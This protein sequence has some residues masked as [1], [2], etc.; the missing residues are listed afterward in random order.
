MKKLCLLF[1]LGC[2]LNSYAAQPTRIFALIV[3]ESHYKEPALNKLKYAESDAAAFA[4]FLKSPQAGAVPAENIIF[5][6]GERATR[7]AVLNAANELFNGRAQENDMIIFYFSGHGSSSLGGGYLMPYDA[8]DADPVSS[9]ISMGQLYDIINNSHAKM[10]A[11]YLDACHAGSYPHPAGSKGTAAEM[12]Q[13]ISRA[14]TKIIADSHPG[15]LNVLSSKGSEESQESETLHGGIF[16][17]YLIKGLQGEADKTPSDGHITADE[18]DD[19]LAKKVT[20]ESGFRQ[21]PVITRT[22]DNNF[23]LSIIDLNLTLADLINKAAV[24]STKQADNIVVTPSVKP[25]N[26]KLS[27]GYYFVDG[28]CFAKAT[29]INN[30]GFPLVM[31]GL[32]DENGYHEQSELLA[33]NDQLPTPKLVIK[34]F[35]NPDQAADQFYDCIFYFKAEINGVT[36][37]AIVRRTVESCFNQY[38]VL[39][40]RNVQFGDQKF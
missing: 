29:F 12:N 28:T 35:I 34:R 40:P 25:A 7:A 16:T 36:K 19:Y 13:E 39:T 14:F 21:H 37:Y 18:L 38:F 32:Q 30:L 4:G 17:Y 15:T 8:Q 26:E 3:G 24:Q 22:I 5:L 6:T 10:K 20:A 9:G 27:R 33:N 23:P 31:T 1:L 11:V 2:C